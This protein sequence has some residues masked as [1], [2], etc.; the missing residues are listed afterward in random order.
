[1]RGIRRVLFPTRAGLRPFWNGKEKA[2]YKPF[3]KWFLL[4]KTLRIFVTMPDKLIIKSISRKG[5]L[6]TVSL[7]DETELLLLQSMVERHRLRSGLEISAEQINIIKAESDFIRADH[8]LGYM[9]GARSYSIGQASQRLAQKGFDK[10]IIGQVVK[11]YIERG[12]LDDAK[13]AR[14]LVS[15]ALRHKPAGRGY[16]LARL[17]SKMIPN[18][19][20]RAAVEECLRDVDEYSVA[21][22]LLEARWDYLSK[23]DLET[24]RRKAYNYLSRRSIGYEAARQAFEKISQEE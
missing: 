19:I 16:L 20:A 12:F 3:K 6:A 4:I 1:M 22:Q 10:T 7:S 9:L 24:A 2:K 11:L 23:F 18:A 15:A 17:Q 13:F 5:R 14:E 21:F 8:H